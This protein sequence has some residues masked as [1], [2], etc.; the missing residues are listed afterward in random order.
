MKTAAI[1]CEYNPFHIGHAYHIAQT[2]THADYILCIMSGSF[3]QRGEVAM[4]DK[5]SR[6]RWALQAGADM[7]IELPCV[8]SLQSAE[9]FARGAVYLAQALGVDYLSFGAECA[10]VD[11][12]KQ[13]AQINLTPPPAYTAAFRACLNQGKPY[14]AAKEAALR[15][16]LD[17]PGSLLTPNSTLGIEYT[18]QIL[19]HKYSI[20]P[21]IIRRDP[22]SIS[23]S[24]CRAAIQHHRLPFVPGYVLASMTTPVTLDMLEEA[25]FYRLR[26]M[27]REEYQALP[28]LSEGLENRIYLA[29]RQGH[30]LSSLVRAIASTRYP[31]ARIKRILCCALLGIQA[32]DARQMPQYARILGFRR[33]SI[34]ASMALRS[35]ATLPLIDRPV[36]I[37]ENPQFQLETRATDI[38]ALACHD[39]SGMDFISPLV[40]I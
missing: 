10:D 26:T 4:F 17:V 21:L 39:P 25:I 35:R 34:A 36:T 32:P 11:P 15:A 12:F 8:H 28:E 9:G 18:K 27:S 13:V 5:F 2:R 22:G 19:L 1:I 37:K 24:Q 7:V 33:D 6:A 20:Q 29:A 38:R 14:A 23:S 40:V 3:V 31:L 16:C 30:S